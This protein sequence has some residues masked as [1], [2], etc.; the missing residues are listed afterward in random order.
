LNRLFWGR[1]CPGEILLSI[2]GGWRSRHPVISG[3]ADWG[4]PSPRTFLARYSK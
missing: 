1:G 3:S 4:T 2:G